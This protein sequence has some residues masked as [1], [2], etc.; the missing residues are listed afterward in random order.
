[1]PE[2]S[3]P[4]VGKPLRVAIPCAGLEPGSKVPVKVIPVTD[5]GGDPIETFEAEVDAA[6]GVARA[7]WTYDHEKHADQVSSA[8]F[9]LV[10]EGAG[11][12]TAS[13]PIEFV[14]RFHA[15]V[16]DSSGNPVAHRVVLLHA[17]R[18]PSVQAQTDDAGQVSALVS[19][20]RY[21]VE[22]TPSAVPEGERLYAKRPPPPDDAPPS[23]SGAGAGEASAP[24][25][26][27]TGTDAGSDDTPGDST[28]ATIRLLLLDEDHAPAPGACWKA[29]GTTPAEG[30]AGDDGAATLQLSPG[31]ERVDLTWTLADGSEHEVSFWARIPADDRDTAA[32]RRLDNLGFTSGPGLADDVAAFQRRWGRS[33]TGQVEDVEQDLA[34]LHDKGTAPAPAADSQPQDP[35]S[36]SAPAEDFPGIGGDGDG[37]SVA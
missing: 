8:V 3:R 23:E 5:L 26:G 14:D 9:L 15:T 20:G 32:R 24:D 1:M 35:G 13:P 29:Q 28:G 37:G 34:A 4:L 22:L 30:T 10:A 18:G 16:K 36:A 11:R 6:G 2:S 7:T 21:H 31:A 12:T 19:P 33:P 17:D 25:G 27:G